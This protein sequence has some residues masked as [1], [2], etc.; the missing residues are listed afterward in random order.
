MNKQ[1]V[2]QCFIGAVCSILVSYQTAAFGS[3]YYHGNGGS[4]SYDESWEP[5][6]KVPKHSKGS[7]P[8]VLV[9][10]AHGNFHTIEQR[11][12]PFAKLLSSDGYAVES[13]NSIVNKKLL[14]Q[15]EIFVIANAIKGGEESSWKLPIEQAFTAQ[16]KALLT[17]W[18]QE[19]G[20]LLLIADHMPFPGAVS[21]LA[22]EFGFGFINGFALPDYDKRG[23]LGFEKETALLGNHPII[24]AVDSNKQ[25]AKV[26]TFTGQ[27][28]TKPDSAIGLL[29]MPKDWNVYLP[30]DAWEFDEATPYL[31]TNNLYQGAVLKYG[32]G[33]VAVFGEAAM[34]TAQVVKREDSVSRYGLNHPEAKDNEQFVLNVMSWLS[35]SLDN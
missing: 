18:V 27:A 4:Q 32:K 11:F 24:N 6:K 20:S 13:T 2:I 25:I 3:V 19:G 8:L 35:G 17:Q 21:E 23:I 28:F 29:K 30:K 34:F 10:N 26:V 7:Q 31:S 14:E 12:K 33:R 22:G 5:S 16:E 1:L 15:V 9:D